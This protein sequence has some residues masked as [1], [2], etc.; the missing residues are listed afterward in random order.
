MKKGWIV[1]ALVIHFLVNTGLLTNAIN[2]MCVSVCVF[3]SE[4]SW[5]VSLSVVPTLEHAKHILQCNYMQLA[6]KQPCHLCPKILL[7]WLSLSVSVFLS[8]AQTHTETHTGDI[9]YPSSVEE[10]RGIHGA[11]VIFNVYHQSVCTPLLSWGGGR[12]NDHLPNRKTDR[13]PCCH[14]VSCD[15]CMRKKEGMHTDFRMQSEGSCEVK[16]IKNANTN[17]M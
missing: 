3:S 8:H 4:C 13:N 14:A 15:I 16:W 5:G 11:I 2:R 1:N 10:Q 7:P 12:Q 6:A 9:P 17:R